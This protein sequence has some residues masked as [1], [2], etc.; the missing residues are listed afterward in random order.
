MCLDCGCGEP[1]DSHGDDRHITMQDLQQAAEASETTPQ[2]AAQ[3]IMNAV[4]M[5]GGQQMQGQQ[6]Q[7]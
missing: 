5:E 7:M 3:N 4:M 1:N 6:S 2:E